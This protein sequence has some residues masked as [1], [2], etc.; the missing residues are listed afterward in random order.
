MANWY[1]FVQDL[2][3]EM[4]ERIDSAARSGKV[5]EEIKVQ[6]KGFSEWNTGITSKDHHPIVQVHFFP[7]LQ[8]SHC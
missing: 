8:T 6:H 2:Y 7:S 1:S 5:P 3:E 4:T